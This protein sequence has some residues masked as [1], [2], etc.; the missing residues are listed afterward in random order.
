[1]NWR[2]DDA[3]GIRA[4]LREEINEYRKILSTRGYLVREPIASH[5]RLLGEKL[6]ANPV[7]QLLR[8]AEKRLLQIG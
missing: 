8:D 7:I 2:S 3:P 1:M 6:V 4:K 5:G